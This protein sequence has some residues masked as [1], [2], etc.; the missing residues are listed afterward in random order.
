[1]EKELSNSTKWMYLANKFF[2]INLSPFFHSD[3]ILIRFMDA[4]HNSSWLF[5]KLFY[6]TNTNVRMETKFFDIE[7]KFWQKHFP[8]ENLNKGSGSKSKS[9]IAYKLQKLK[10]EFLVN[11]TK[12]KDKRMMVWSGYW[13][14]WCW[15]V[16]YD[17]DG[18]EGRR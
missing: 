17:W 13:W 8:N 9:W 1:M 15:G 6:N 4:A 7:R 5:S 11:A 12:D 10:D 14:G 2:C 16:V 18:K 3:T